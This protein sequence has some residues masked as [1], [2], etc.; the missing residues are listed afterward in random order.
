MYDK[1]LVVEILQLIV[2]S[3][4]RILKKT[5]VIRCHDDFID[6]EEKRYSFDIICMQLAAIGEG[7]KKVD[8]LTDGRSLI[9]Y[10]QVDWKGLKGI[11]DVISHQYFNISYKAVLTHAVT[12]SPVS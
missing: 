7:L 5:R 9:N 3:A 4:E 2:S 6:S 10:T 1:L 11:R 12:I 8:K